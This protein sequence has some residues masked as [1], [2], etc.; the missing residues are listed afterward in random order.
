MKIPQLIKDAIA[1]KPNKTVEFWLVMND[2]QYKRYARANRARGN[3][4]KALQKRWACP[5]KDLPWILKTLPD[6]PW[7]CKFPTDPYP[8][9]HEAPQLAAEIKRQTQHLTKEPAHA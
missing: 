7:R 3:S 8:N 2:E 6:L 9:I 5:V 4:Y 1:E